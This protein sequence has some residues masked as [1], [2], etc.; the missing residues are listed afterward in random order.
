[1]NTKLFSVHTRYDEENWYK[2]T[3]RLCFLNL[4]TGL[5]VII[6]LFILQSIKIIDWPVADTLLRIIFSIASAIILGMSLATKRA[7]NKEFISTLILIV[8]FSIFLYIN[9]LIAL[10]YLGI[11]LIIFSLTLFYIIIC[12][13]R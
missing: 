4:G 12:N 10:L 1:M 13:N 9:I 11:S 6:I 2:K 5:L 8:G 3:L 7:K